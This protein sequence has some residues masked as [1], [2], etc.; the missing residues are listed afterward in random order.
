MSAVDT[1][2]QVIEWALLDAA[3][4]PP[5]GDLLDAGALAR[6]DE[7][8]KAALGRLAAVTAAR[9]RLDSPVLGKG[10]QLGVGEVILAAALGALHLPVLAHTLL[11]AVPP[12]SYP[13]QWVTRHG[14][15][16]PALPFLSSDRTA[17]LR[18]ACLRASP[19]TA[20]LADPP[21][22]Q[23]GDL[24]KLALDL[25]EHPAGRR[26]LQLALAEPTPEPGIRRWRQELL[27]RLRLAG[28]TGREFV[29][30]VY[31][32]M[33]IHYPEQALQ[34]LRTAR[35][36]LTDARAAEERLRDALA[37]AAWWQPL[38]ALQRSHPEALRA[39][40][41]LGYDYREGIALYRLAQRL[42]GGA[43]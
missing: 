41:Y 29:L 38:W 23:Q 4:P 17:E 39:R 27:E 32:A 12:V 11:Q 7:P 13:I 5:C 19:F 24:V 22:T 37:V 30:D 6:P 10:G 8:L 15:V 42:T 43:P 18:E 20:L 16:V 33:L 40:R 9:L 21:H 2:S 26:L 3:G 35:V 14:L 25:L 1:A 31:E 28:E 36:V 34:Q